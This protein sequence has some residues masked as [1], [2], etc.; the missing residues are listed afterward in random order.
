MLPMKVQLVIDFLHGNLEHVSLRP[1]REPDQKYRD[2]LEVVQ[3]GSLTLQDL[4]YFCL[5]TLAT[6][7]GEKQA[8]WLSRW[9]F[10]TGVYTAAGDALHLL[11][12]LQTRRANCVELAVH[13]GRSTAC[14]VA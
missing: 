1:G 10:G 2:Y 6:I 8:Y 3:A 7:G 14:R 12:V 13:W 9:L 11:R 5:D 4:G